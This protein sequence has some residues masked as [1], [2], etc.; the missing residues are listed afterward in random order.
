MYPIRKST[1]SESWNTC[2]LSSPPRYR[3]KRKKPASDQPYM[4]QTHRAALPLPHIP[5]ILPKRFKSQLFI[6]VAYHN[7]INIHTLDTPLPHIL[8]RFHHQRQP[9][10]FPS[11]AFVNANGSNE[12]RLLFRRH[13]RHERKDTSDDCGVRTH[14]GPSDLRVSVRVEGHHYLVVLI[15]GCESF[16]GFG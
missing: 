4:H 12:S 2:L 11:C 15:V 13:Q 16:V 10:T 8:Y 14:Q 5:L 6:E 9:H 1:F 3:H 7:R